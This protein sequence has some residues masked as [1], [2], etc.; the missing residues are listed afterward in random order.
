MGWLDSVRDRKERDKIPEKWRDKPVE[1]IASQLTASEKLAKDLEDEKKARV[2]DT[3]K[4]TETQRQLDE[5]R[6]R[7]AAAEARQTPPTRQEPAKQEELANFVEEPD[8]AFSQRVGPLLNVAVHNSAQTARILAQQQLT[9][10]DLSNSNKTM[11][12]RL[13]QAWSSEL[14]AEAKKYG[15]DKM[16]TPESWLGVFF[17][18]KGLHADELRDPEIRKKKYNFLE[19][20]A[21]PDGAPPSERQAKKDE[22]TAEELRVAEK[23]GVSPENY[24]KRKKA[25]TFVNA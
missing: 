10:M 12:G 13:F 7:L 25:M 23:M 2:A 5:V 9:N 14:D 6:A 4:I 20:S 16:M 19:P 24:L 15:P 18:L 8:K 17:Y 21:T 11:D 3:E 22:L 1:E